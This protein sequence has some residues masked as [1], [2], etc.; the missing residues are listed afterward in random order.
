MRCLG[1]E[2]GPHLADYHWQ[3]E[4]DQ[5]RL[6]HRDSSTQLGRRHGGG[7]VIDDNISVRRASAGLGHPRRPLGLEIVLFFLLTVTVVPPTALA[8]IVVTVL[9]V[10]PDTLVCL[11]S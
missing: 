9:V 4:H 10:G 7:S 1:A 8:I 11:L 6:H 3:E 2:Q 5:A